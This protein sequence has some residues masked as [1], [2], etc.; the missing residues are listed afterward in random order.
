MLSP[1]LQPLLEHTVAAFAQLVE[2]DPRAHVWANLLDTVRAIVAFV[3]ALGLALIQ[4]YVDVR[5]RQTKATHRTCSCG[6]PMEW[7]ANSAWPHGTPFGEVQVRDAYAY[8]RTCH[9]SAR[10][11]HGWLGTA[12]SNRY[13]PCPCMAS[14]CREPSPSITSLSSAGSTLSADL[15]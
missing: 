3:A 7:L 5:L 8:C 1:A 13:W 6:E 2:Q 14:A 4:T 12:M 15:T 9:K 10:P 11:L